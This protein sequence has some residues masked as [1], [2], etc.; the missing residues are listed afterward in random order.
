MQ[1]T[2]SPIRGLPG[3]PETQLSVDGERLTCDGIVYDLSSVPEGGRALPP[4]DESH[5]FLGVLTRRSGEVQATLRVVL[6]GDAAP[7]QSRDE[8]DWR[9]V[10]EQGPVSIPVDRVESAAAAATR[11]GEG[12]A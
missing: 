10:V 12:R 8:E 6:G 7:D 4:E 9:V 2:L 11:Q 3:Q 5:P 1:L